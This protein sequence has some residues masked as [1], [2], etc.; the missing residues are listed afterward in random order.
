MSRTHRIIIKTDFGYRNFLKIKETSNGD[1]I[2]SPRGIKHSV[3]LSNVS[4]NKAD[5]NQSTISN[6]TV[7][8]NLKSSIG[9]ITINFKDKCN[10]QETR[11][12]A[13]L[14]GVK[15]N[16][17][18]YPILASIGRNLSVPRL[19]HDYIS[20]ESGIFELWKNHGINLKSDS[21][22][23]VLAVCNKDL[24]INFP[25]DFPRNTKFFKFKHL[26]LVLFYWLYNQPTKFRG[27]SLNMNTGGDYIPGM[28]PHE[29]LNL[30]NDL[31]MTHLSH[32]NK[33]ADI[34][35]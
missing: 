34:Q 21:L 17:R 26:K 1:I 11:E 27:T 10:G 33:L 28:L 22:A 31:T 14:L 2:V 13:G 8:P 12:I 24:H 18:M 30:T 15:E 5:E 9:S 16:E 35:S 3:P 32:Y 20:D 19:E 4:S 23:Y 7:H 29:L 6:I 25:E